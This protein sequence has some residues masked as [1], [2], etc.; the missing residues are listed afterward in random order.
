MANAEV[1]I[2]YISKIS[3]D[4]KGT[5]YISIYGLEV[6]YEK[7]GQGFSVCTQRNNFRAWGWT[8]EDAIKHLQEKIKEWI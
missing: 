7:D 4:E 5:D 8:K 3:K 1:R 2:G 6:I